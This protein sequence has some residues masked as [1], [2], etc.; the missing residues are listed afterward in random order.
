[1]SPVSLFASD[2][3]LQISFPKRLFR[4]GEQIE[5][6]ITFRNVSG[7][8]IRVLP[9]IWLFS[10]QMISVRKHPEDV[11]RERIRP[12][13]ER[14]VD[15]SALGPYVVLLN[16][17]DA[18]IRHYVAKLVS[19]LPSEY[20][21]TGSGLYLLFST[22]AIKL[23]GFGR[24]HISAEYDSMVDQPTGSFPIDNPRLW[25]GKVHSPPVVVE[26]RAK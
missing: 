2:L 19:S 16:P 24:Y 1:M 12:N 7:E 3:Q 5:F 4:L 21:N 9:E 15:L 20:E 13:I 23:D 8:P 26:F 11:E 17:K 6:D 25:W 18:L 22:A 10:T 14:N